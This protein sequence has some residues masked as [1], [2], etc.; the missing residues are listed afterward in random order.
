MVKYEEDIVLGL[1][2]NQECPVC[3]VYYAVPGAR[4]TSSL[5]PWWTPLDSYSIVFVLLRCIPKSLLTFAPFCSLSAL[6]YLPLF[7]YT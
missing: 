6:T 1:W 7:L 4:Q 5:L 2:K 3:K